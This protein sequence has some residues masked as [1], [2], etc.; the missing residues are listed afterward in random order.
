MRF[1]NSDSGFAMVNNLNATIIGSGLLARSFSDICFKNNTLILAS[2]VSNSRELRE[3]EFSR[4]I[5][6]VR[7]AIEKNPD[8]AVVY[9]S[10]CSLVNGPVTPYTKHKMKVENLVANA[11]ST[12]YI[13]RL[14]Q[15]VGVV[16][17]STL[18]SYFVKSIVGNK[19][20]NI[21]SKAKRNL[22]D[23]MDVARLTKALVDGGVGVNSIQ[24]IASARSV[25]VVDIVNEL[26][27]ILGQNARVINSDSGDDQAVD[28]SFLIQAIGDSDP[29]FLE[30][31]WRDVLR[32]NVPLLL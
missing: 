7:R 30:G 1:A 3:S 26:S 27:V 16:Q 25:S 21:Q 24:N 9:F 12:F 29:V 32:K 6:L 23:V 18:V 13:F 2:G 11:A 15:V 10:T 22:L 19:V 4:E 14:P 17:N 28:V 5:S 8:S 20:L 31:Y